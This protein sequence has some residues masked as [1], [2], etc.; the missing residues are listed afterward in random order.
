[1]GLLNELEKATK[2]K[3]VYFISYNNPNLSSPIVI[4][5]TESL[6]QATAFEKK[7]KG[8]SI[9]DMALTMEAR[10]VNSWLVLSSVSPFNTYYLLN[11]Y[12]LLLI[13]LIRH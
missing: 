10:K 4:Q 7:Q 1:M 8:G 5:D 9:T 13:Y 2:I 3:K 12:I 6:Q 11:Y